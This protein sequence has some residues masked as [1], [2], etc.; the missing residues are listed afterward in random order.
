MRKYICILLI[1]I[2]LTTSMGMV[3]TSLYSK[4][5]NVLPRLTET[6]TYIGIPVAEE[7]DNSTDVEEDDNST[8]NDS[9]LPNPCE[10]IQFHKAM[11][12]EV[13]VP[14][15]YLDNVH[16]YDVNMFIFSKD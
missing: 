15:Q 4:P 12:D 1:L 6:C 13:I 3:P 9:Y 5:D 8:E 11:I 7:D 16:G 2:M 14:T 10:Y